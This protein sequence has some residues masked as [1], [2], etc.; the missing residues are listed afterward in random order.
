MDHWNYS[1]YIFFNH[2]TF[3]QHQSEHE[4]NALFKVEHCIHT[5]HGIGDL[6]SSITQTSSLQDKVFSSEA[7]CT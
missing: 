7:K 3:E 2:I 1:V 4:T 6:V 5:N